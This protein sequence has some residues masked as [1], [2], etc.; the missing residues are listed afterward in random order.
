MAGTVK[1]SGLG[2]SSFGLRFSGMDEEAREFSQ[3]KIDTRRLSSAEWNRLV[4]AK[5]R[6]ACFFSA[7]VS[8]A[9]LLGEMQDY[10]TK[11][12]KGESGYHRDEFIKR[13]R[14]HLGVDESAGAGGMSKITSTPRLSLVYDHQMA[15]MNGKKQR[16]RDLERAEFFPVLEFKRIERRKEP[17]PWREKWARLGGKFYEGRMI[18]PV[19]DPIWTELS[20]FG[21]PYPPFAFNSGMGTW[22]LSV[23]E[24]RR[25][26]AVET[27]KKGDAETEEKTEARKTA[28][29]AREDG[30]AGKAPFFDEKPEK[31]A[32][33][34]EESGIP[35]KIESEFD[36]ETYDAPIKT[37]S[38][39]GIGE[40]NKRV[41]EAR[42]ERSLRSRLGEKIVKAD[43]ALINVGKTGDDA[44]TAWKARA[45]EVL[46]EAAERDDAGKFLKE[47]RAGK[48]A[49]AVEKRF[50]AVDGVS[51]ANA[52]LPK[53]TRGEEVAETF[54]N[55]V[56]DIMLGVD[57]FKLAAFV[58]KNPEK[59]LKRGN[60]EFLFG[61][62]F[63]GRWKWFRAVRVAGAVGTLC[64][65]AM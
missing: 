46:A 34:R 38:G 20:E 15:A 21:T 16:V 10:I 43:G 24:A 33:L 4:D 53:T 63:G 45:R 12:A 28:Q 31:R 48:S 2:G 11:A 17:R 39:A 29:E 35:A 9:K 55:F 64:F 57:L 22:R 60:G 59:I 3:R 26:G 5:T 30:D 52:V 7:N 42:L 13:C 58:A 36:G 62:R 54:V 50:V 25:L 19:D 51:P 37:T 23:A 18:A 44:G 14:R 61:R 47:L 40:G 32:V 65:K 8:N 27:P 1:G 56:F 49:S 41:I 6:E